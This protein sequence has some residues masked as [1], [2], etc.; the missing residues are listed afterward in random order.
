MQSR[1][2]KID[3]KPYKSPELRVYGTISEITLATGPTGAH[4]AGI[5]PSD[6][7]A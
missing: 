3:K 2:K 6:K 5:A 7:T 4:D 1:E